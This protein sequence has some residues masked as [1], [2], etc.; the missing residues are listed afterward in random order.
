MM[1]AGAPNSG[2]G[3]GQAVRAGRV[4]WQTGQGQR[5]ADRPAG[6]VILLSIKGGALGTLGMA[7]HA[8]PCLS[9]CAWSTTLLARSVCSLC[10]MTAVLMAA[11]V[12]FR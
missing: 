10:A 5:E 12:V 1:R 8:I 4:R 2:C 6:R 7:Q 3:R 11:R 9:C